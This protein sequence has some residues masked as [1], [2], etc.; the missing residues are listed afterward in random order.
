M[1]AATVIRMVIS[2]PRYTE[3]QID[4]VDTADR[5]GRTISIISDSHHFAQPFIVPTVTEAR[6]AP[7]SP[8]IPR[9]NATEDRRRGRLR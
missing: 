7:L 9:G 6:G 5:R 4:A 1:T 3:A 2:D 8:F